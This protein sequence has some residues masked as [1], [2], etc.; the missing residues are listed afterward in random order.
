MNKFF[1]ALM[2][3]GLLSFEA[4]ANS[5]EPSKPFSCNSES[6]V[7][8]NEGDWAGADASHLDTISLLDGT[9]THVDD[10]SG[11]KGVN[12]IG[13]NI[14]DNMLWGWNIGAEKVVRIDANKN[15][16]LYDID[17][18]PKRFYV[19]ADV[20]QDGILCLFSR[21][22]SSEKKTIVRVDLNTLKLL[23]EVTLDKEINTADFAFNV[24][25]NKLY[26]IQAGTDDL[27]AI[28]FDDGFSSDIF[29]SSIGGKVEKV[30]DLGLSS[31]VPIINY[32]DKDGNFYFN[33]DTKNMYKF[34]VT[35]KT[36]TS[37]ATWFSALE[38]TLRNG[39]GA[40]CANAKVEDTPPVDTP[41]PFTCDDGDLY[42]SYVT[43]GH[44]TEGDSY[45]K[46]FS[47]SDDKSGNITLS[48]PTTGVNSIGYNLKDNYI[49]GYNIPKRKVVRIDANYNVKYYEMNH[50]PDIGDA[51]YNAADVSPDGVLYLKFDNQND[52]LD[53]VKLETDSQGK[54]QVMS[55]IQ[56][57][58][59][60]NV[61]DF[62]F[63]PKDGKIYFV[64]DYLKR[65]DIDEATLT[66]EIVKVSDT[67]VGDSGH[68]V[69][70]F[71]KDGNFYYNHN[72]EYL[73]RIKINSDGTLE[74]T[75]DFKR[76]SGL[77]QGDGARCANASIE[78]EPKTA[79]SIDDSSILEGDSGVKDI[80]FT[81]H[82][83]GDLSQEIRLR[84]TLKEGSATK[85]SD[86]VDKSEEFTMA[87]GM[88]SY[89]LSLPIILGD[90]DVE[91]D[92]NF[93]IELSSVGDSSMF[94][95]M[96]IGGGSSEQNETI[97]ASAT[98]VILNDDLD[99]FPCDYNSYIFTSP[100]GANYTKALSVGIADRSVTTAKESFGDANIN[101]I[102]FNP[103]DGFIYGWHYDTSSSSPHSKR[104]VKIDKHYNVYNVDLNQTL[105]DENFYLGDVSKDGI[106]YLAR[107]TKLSASGELKEI[108]R[109]NLTNKQ[110]LSKITLTYPNE[111]ATIRTADFAI[112][113]KDDQLYVVNSRDNNLYKINVVGSDI[114]KVTKLGYVGDIGNT[115]SVYNFFDVEGNFYFQVHKD[116][117]ENGESVTK[118]MIYKIDISEPWDGVDNEKAKATFFGFIDTA[119]SGDGARCA[120][121]PISDK[122][123]F[124]ITQSYVEVG[125]GDSNGADGT[126]GV[127]I[128]T[129]IK[130]NITTSES[131]ELIA[132]IAPDRGT[133]TRGDDY[134]DLQ[135]IHFTFP[136]GVDHYTFKTT[137]VRG[138]LKPEADENFF[139]LFGVND[140]EKGIFDDG[141]KLL[142]V[143]ILDDDSSIFSAYDTDDTHTFI[144]DRRIKTKVATE[145]FSLVL[146]PLMPAYS[147]DINK[148]TTKVKIVDATECDKSVSELD[149]QSFTPF[150]LTDINTTTKAFLVNR[151]FKD[152]RVQFLWSDTKGIK[153]TSCSIDHF[154]IR[155]KEFTF[156]GGDMSASSG[157]PKAL[158]IVAG[159][160]STPSMG[161]N[162]SRDISFKIDANQTNTSCSY[163]PSDLDDSNITTF[164]DGILNGT[165]KYD[166]VGV[167]D[168]NISEIA[169]SEFALIDLNDTNDSLRFIKPA[170]I[171]MTFTPHHYDISVSYAN[172]H[173]NSD[174]AFYAGNH[175]MNDG[176][177]WTIG[178]TAKNYDNTIATNFN[179]D[180][181]AKDVD[182]TMDL[183][184]SGSQSY[185]NLQTDANKS[186]GEIKK[187]IKKD[188]FI[189]GVGSSMVGINFTKPATPTDPTLLKIKKI[190]VKDPDGVESNKTSVPPSSGVVYQ[191][192]RAHM[193]S[194]VEVVGKKEIKLDVDYEGYQSSAATV[195]LKGNP[196][197]SK[198][199][200][201]G[202]YKIDFIAGSSKMYFYNQT[203][204]YPSRVTLS[205]D[206]N[207]TLVVKANNLPEKNRVTIKV[208]DPEFKYITDGVS[209]DVIFTPDRANWAGKGKRGK[210]VDTNVSKRDTFRKMDW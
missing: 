21:E 92:E 101:A 156:V 56:L 201:N 192:M 206:S 8:W 25:D 78:K 69:A 39:D 209:S 55:S 145:E 85:D 187:Q 41:K 47:L 34:D 70:M 132:G 182:I 174:F 3:F 186:A 127:E 54:L 137:V 176:P 154:A 65:I 44:A 193:L 183:N 35:H 119:G 99:S 18:I 15:A 77:T 120:L 71:D 91:E 170:S 165:I 79:I 75:R 108:Y 126:N 76:I 94:D 27:Y 171:E 124:S 64:D 134:K 172:G 31:V 141:Y 2:S 90:K 40:R 129:T 115:Y 167:I 139:F 191:Y 122:P 73:N 210:V 169:G 93:T 177:N 1:L 123:I 6:F 102:G 179:K 136:A 46:I 173:T 97:V 104:V 153:H 43:S 28:T 89:T 175:D 68:K 208:A 205:N 144:G 87:S 95:T 105:P 58:E 178:V 36:P 135:P 33:K 184:I 203:A 63:N 19:A 138:D 9:R 148:T 60:L 48:E 103:V 190:N 74:I 29:S 109:I 133:A 131:V 72:D 100:S 62:A 86:F 185:T 198:S 88:S 17:G 81:I 166:N 162:E 96:P 30:A 160:S 116:V 37:K 121:A 61:D 149:E 118:E 194:P 83:S 67:K 7:S 49:W 117:V 146:S 14:K 16:T 110:F 130:S 202:W 106:Y 12:S 157:E 128:S 80:S 52:R 111:T 200:E 51:Y 53:R 199:G 125:E 180:C 188:S 158:Q 114:G 112:N 161:Y 45:L 204:K 4:V 152:A 195:A 22:S 5:N 23:P 163:S 142:E 143:K 140:D 196:K 66:G 113:P 10:A 57:N 168:L 189:G 164:T 197:P 84:Y 151:A 11:V 82:R 13:Y 98:G 24:N 32:F 59:G 159:D 107:M 50:K 26:F 207:Q 38:K 150:S 147:I 42:V 20:T 155:P 181:I